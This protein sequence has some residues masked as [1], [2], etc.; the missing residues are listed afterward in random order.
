M[1]QPA[2]GLSPSWPGRP[3]PEAELLQAL[4][5][6]DA[7]LCR[8][9]LQQLVHRRGVSA[10]ESLRRR[11]LALEPD[12]QGWLWLSQLLSSEPIGSLSASSGSSAAVTSS[13]LPGSPLPVA[14]ALQERQ[15][16]VDLDLRVGA[17]VDA[18]FEALAAEFPA[19]A[20]SAF[21]APSAP[22]PDASASPAAQLPAEPPQPAAR[23]VRDLQLDSS[24]AS[25]AQSRCSFVIPQPPQAD[26]LDSE[27]AEARQADQQAMELPQDG[28]GS[29]PAGPVPFLA[30]GSEPA[31]SRW[32]TG[33]W[34]RAEGRLAGL[35]DRV[36]SGLSL[37]RVR[38]LVRDCVEEAVSSLHGPA[39]DTDVQ[40]QDKW[41][42][43]L[44]AEEPEVT[45]AAPA[46]F[47]S[48][49]PTPQPRP[50]SSAGSGHQAPVAAFGPPLSGESWAAST[51]AAQSPPRL[52]TAQ[53]L[54]QTLLG[55]SQGK[56]APAPSPQALSDLRAWLPSDDDL[57]RAS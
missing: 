47:W 1:S 33:F 55:R 50:E 15:G 14:A 51:A 16:G 13:P 25:S 28:A 19:Y 39:G 4:G 11:S 38:A 56:T 26:P 22:G 48:L 43:R 7:A 37:S 57:P 40:R 18:A 24:L 54:R 46:A 8:S 12:Q 42:Q 6:R 41:A 20:L 3:D 44:P 36:T 9:R 30:A 49:E 53:Q 35:R 21:A 32:A 52:S 31:G 27:Q 23:L 2:P 10:L 17:A 5:R 34:S 29:L 45:A